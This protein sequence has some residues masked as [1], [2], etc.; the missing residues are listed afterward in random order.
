MSDMP[1]IAPE[2][3]DLVWFRGADALRFLNDIVS[4]ELEDMGVGEARRSFLLGPQGK[5]QF[6][7]WVIR[8]QE[9][10]GLLTDPGRGGDLAAALNRYKIRV[11]VDVV[12]ED[13]EVWIVVGGHDGYD[14]S[15]PGVERALVIGPKPELAA[16]TEDEYERL[17][18]MAGEPR[19]GIDVDEGTIPHA[20]GLVPVSVDFDK[21]CFL[22]QEL[23]ARIDSRGGN[24]P[25]SLLMVQV[26]GDINAGDA[27]TAGDGEVG[28][29]TSATAGLG[30]AMLKRGVSPGDRVAV[31]GLPASVRELPAKTR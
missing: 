21:G 29:V 5:L 31:G 10:I 20:S 6:L 12:P 22:G 13:R 11:D 23:V 30:L 19:W 8:D 18:I 7:L 4:Q 27:V 9:G 15:W 25:K 1:W 26:E 3:P 2:K 14:I 17:R 16:G 28:T 24:T